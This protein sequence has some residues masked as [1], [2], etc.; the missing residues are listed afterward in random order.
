MHFSGILDS[1]IWNPGF[2]GLESWILGFGASRS[3]VSFYSIILCF[4][5][6]GEDELFSCII[7]AF[8]S[9]FVKSFSLH[10]SRGGE[11][12]SAGEST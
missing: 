11:C 1:G 4:V 12:K 10:L 9:Y 7:S 3:E 8:V 5:S 6:E 2:W